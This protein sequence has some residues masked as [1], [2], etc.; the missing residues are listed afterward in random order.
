MVEQ[1]WEWTPD[2]AM[3]MAVTLQEAG[4]P[5]N[6]LIPIADLVESTAYADCPIQV[7]GTDATREGKVRKWP[8]LPCYKAEKTAAFLKGQLQ[9]YKDAGIKLNG[10]WLDD[11]CLP[12]A[13]NGCYEAQKS[14]AQSRQQYPWD[15]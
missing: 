11:E 12:H 4:R 9:R 13:W 8:C 10:V 2:G 1:G 15:V 3:A 7:E 6:I 14:T 5:V